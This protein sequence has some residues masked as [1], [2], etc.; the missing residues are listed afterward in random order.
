M[1]YLLKYFLN[2][3]RDLC[4]FILFEHN[5]TNKEATVKLKLT[6]WT[7]NYDQANQNT[8]ASVRVTKPLKLMLFCISHFS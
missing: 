1:E 7:V 6:T 3:S 2:D 5:L 8:G 4:D